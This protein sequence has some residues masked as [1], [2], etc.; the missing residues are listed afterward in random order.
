MSP[1][2]FS[3][4]IAILFLSNSCFALG[5]LPVDLGTAGNYAILS[6]TGTS[7]VEPS[8]IT[9]D[10]GVS[11]AAATYLTG[12]ALTLSADGTYSTSSQVNGKCYAADYTSPTPAKLTAAITDMKTA[13][14][15]AST[16]APATQ[17]DLK[18]GSIGGATF[19]PGIY[20]WTTTVNI[21]TSITL[22]GTVLDTWI[23]QIAGTLDMAS[24]QKVLLVGGASPANI[25]WAV[26]GAVTLG[27]NTVFEGVLLAQT[28]ITPQTNAAVNGRL[29]AQS[30]IALQK[31][32]ITQ[33]S[34]SQLS[35][36]L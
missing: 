30:A 13:Y 32:T 31:S 18:G 2:I 10:I 35:L 1:R 24:A 27:T 4:A 11:A 20:K 26:A 9:G 19:T 28:G 8:D 17:T 22:E 16:R 3:L 34:T 33:P 29:L 23:F 7:T 36:G 15:D 5:P 12:F 25:V 6:Q 14:T 21:A